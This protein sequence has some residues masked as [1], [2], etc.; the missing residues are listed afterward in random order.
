MK[1]EELRIKNEELKIKNHCCPTKSTFI[2]YLISLTLI[3]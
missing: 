3:Y 1:N 2:F